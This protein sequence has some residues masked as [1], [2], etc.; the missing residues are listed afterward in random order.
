[1][2]CH[3][4]HFFDLR[5]FLR[6]RMRNNTRWSYFQKI[7]H[8]TRY[9]LRVNERGSITLSCIRRQLGGDKSLYLFHSCLVNRLLSTFLSLSV[10]FSPLLFDIAPSNYLRPTSNKPSSTNRTALFI[11]TRERK[12]R[13]KGKREE[14]WKVMDETL[15]KKRGNLATIKE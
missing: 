6:E 12:E 8:T 2:K 9:R 11:F 1:M 7:N 10:R 14:S 15:D 4:N 5:K 13:E 3:G